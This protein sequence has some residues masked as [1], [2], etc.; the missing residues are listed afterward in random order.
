MTVS[1][2]STPGSFYFFL[3]NIFSGTFCIMKIVR[4]EYIINVQHS[5]LMRTG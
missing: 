5:G 2:M 1:C 4:A 3:L